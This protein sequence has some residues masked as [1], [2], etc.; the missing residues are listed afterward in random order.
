[1]QGFPAAHFGEYSSLIAASLLLALFVLASA[2]CKS[3]SPGG[4]PGG[5]VAPTITSQP[6]NQTVVVGQAATFT[7]AATGTAPLSYQWQKGATGI[8]GATSASYTTPATV[9]AD[10][11]ST[12]RVVVTNSVGNAT[13]NS[14]TL[15]VNPVPPPSN[16]SVLTYHNDNARTGLNPN[17]T[18]LTTSNVRSLTFRKLGSLAV[19]GLVDAEP[20]YVGNL[21]VGGRARN[22]VFVATEHDMVYAFDAD[23]F[24][25]LWQKSV[26]GAG[27]SPSDDRGCPQVTPEIGVTST[28]VID[29][30]QGPN[31]TI[32]VVAMSK[33][34]NSY[35]QRLHALD[36][37]TGAE[38]AGSP[39]TISA[40]FEKPGHPGQFV[41]FDPKQYKERAALLL[42]NGVIYTTWASHCD[43][44]PYTGWI[45]GYSESTLQQTS[46]LNVTPNGTRG[47]IWMSGGG[48]AADSS[49]NIYLLDANGTFDTTLSNGFPVNGD[50][51]NA[52]LKLSTGGNSLAV[53]DY[54]NMHDTV[55]Q[56]NADLDFGSG[57]AVVLLDVRDNGGT[58]WHLAVGAGKDS[59]IY[60]VNRDNMGKFNP[61]ND[62]AAYQVVSGAFPCTPNVLECV[63]STPAFF[64]NTLY[65]GAVADTLKAFPFVNARLASSTSHSPATFVYP[66][67]TPSISSNGTSNG[68]V[69][70]IEGC[71]SATSCTGALHAYDAA[72]LANEFYNSNQAGG[73]R[74]QFSTNR[75]CKYVTPMIANGKVYVGTP[76]A[77]VVFGLLP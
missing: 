66:G 43:F 42:L 64:N 33:S 48:P 9:Q 62:S 29:L 17:E 4:N 58:T 61:N 18:I 49:G 60:V 25:M 52:F 46:V 57:G 44:D 19:T 53:A 7:V 68:I 8:A 3:T 27:E 15:T 51:G 71:R 54:F 26:L 47:A 36:L 63:F 24:S 75:N 65:Y 45:M 56:S 23:T 67:T 41:T 74:D 69:W 11:G 6:S 16:V 13:S 70:A 39:T 55:A 72:N 31:G 20:L 22:V 2:G 77:V 28:P 37:T 34:G 38:Q 40:T 5:P 50:Y 12:Y 76:N 32:F 1:L 35:F 59:R 14:A 30:N 21:T 73:G 10:S